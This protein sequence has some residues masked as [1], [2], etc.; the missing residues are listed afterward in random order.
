MS[1]GSGVVCADFL[2]SLGRRTLLSPGYG[3]TNPVDMY[4]LKWLT[5]SGSSASGLVSLPAKICSFFLSQAALSALT[6][7]L[8]FT[9][10]VDGATPWVSGI[11]FGTWVHG[12]KFWAGG[13]PLRKAV[14]I[15]DA[16]RS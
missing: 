12:A 7:P 10:A 15:G 11:L 2:K 4:Q 5:K 14:L 6:F 8:S 13:T 1:S 9:S 3:R 16:T